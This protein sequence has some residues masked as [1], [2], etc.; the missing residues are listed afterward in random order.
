MSLICKARRIV[1]SPMTVL[2]DLDYR[3]RSV[4]A[5][6]SRTQCSFFCSFAKGEVFLFPLTKLEVLSYKSVLY[7]ARG[8]SCLPPERNIVVDDLSTGNLSHALP[9]LLYEVDVI[10]VCMCHICMRKY[11]CP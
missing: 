4:L 7:D 6:G 11:G 10:C 9:V 2:I 1:L 3:L 8:F 5:H